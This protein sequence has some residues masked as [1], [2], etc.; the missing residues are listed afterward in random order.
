VEMKK[1]FLY[2][3]V[4]AI[5]LMIL[6]IV[7][8]ISGRYSFL[9]RQN[10]EEQRIRT[11]NEFLR[12]FYDDVNQRATYIISARAFI[13]LDDY[14]ANHTGSYIT[15][16]EQKFDVL[17]I[18]GTINGSEASPMIDST[19]ID[20]LEKIRLNAESL[21]L[22]INVTVTNVSLEQSEP[23]YVNVTINMTINLTDRLGAAQWILNK[24]I[25][26]QVKITDLEDPFYTLNCPSTVSIIQRSPYELNELV[27]DT[28]NIN[29]TSK[30][31]EMLERHNHTTYFFASEYA[32]S[33]LMRYAGNFSS[34]P[35]GIFSFVDL[36]YLKDQGCKRI[37][38]NKSSVDYIYF[39]W[40]FNASK[41]TFKNKFCQDIPLYES[42]CNVQ[43]LPDWFR[44]LLYDGPVED[45]GCGATPALGLL[46]AIDLNITDES[47]E[48]YL[49]FDSPSFTGVSCGEMPAPGPPETVC[50]DGWIGEGENCEDGHP[51]LPG[52]V[53]DDCQCIAELPP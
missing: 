41:Y 38:Y 44:I 46:D 25:E 19:F 13:A 23:W 28:D 7:V 17:F 52:Y 16:V 45:L 22:D 4:V 27:N 47:M 35:Y 40:W 10:I 21:N 34:S 9:D 33:F 24:S 3:S 1:G 2:T 20:Y 5:F 36:E 6:L 15:D 14:L 51:C 11:M 8:F 42:I 29:D 12:D 50:G 30:F 31:I 53:C 48:M 43:N 32:P 37:S 26:T 49:E 18:N 39:N